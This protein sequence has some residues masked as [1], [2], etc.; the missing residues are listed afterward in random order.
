[1]HLEIQYANTDKPV[2]V[3]RS[4][5]REDGKIK[6]KQFGRITGQPLELLK[7][8]QL[9]FRNKVI[10]EDD[11]K[12]FQI[13]ES[14]EYGASIAILSV[15]K[16]IG[17]DRAMYSQP[18]QWVNDISAMIAGR[19]IYAGSKLSLCNQYMRCTHFPNRKRRLIK[20]Y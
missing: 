9:T 15:I 2:G 10:P 12:A 18:K 3:I 11:P 7:M 20:V 1:M 19:I 5:Y 17:L 4:S 14:K 8:L 13:V 6:H 16:E